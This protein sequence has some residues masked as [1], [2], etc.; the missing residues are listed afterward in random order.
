MKTTQ[1]K[2]PKTI[3]LNLKLETMKSLSTDEAS[4]VVAGLYDCCR[5]GTGTPSA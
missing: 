3:A 4:G 5:Y 2:K 1:P